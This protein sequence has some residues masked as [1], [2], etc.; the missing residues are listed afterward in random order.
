MSLITRGLRFIE[1][2][3]ASPA[4]QPPEGK[5][6]IHE[7]K[8][9]GFRCQ[10]LLERGRTRIFTRLSFSVA[11]ISAGG[12]AFMVTSI[13]MNLLCCNLGVKSGEARGPTNEGAKRLPLERHIDDLT[14][15]DGIKFWMSDG[16][17]P[18]LCRVSHGCEILPNAFTSRAL[19]RTS[20]K[21]IASL[22]SRSQ[23]MLT[24]PVRA[25]ITL[26]SFSSLPR[27]SPEWAAAHER[28]PRA[29]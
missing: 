3:L 14:A 27:R 12:C 11:R 29:V 5:Q 20:S 17:C 2:Q 19:T 18:V 8:H 23:A 15:R 10:V 6:W 16:E 1:P 4:D 24:T 13:P 26:A 25:L 7:I 9:D 21:P 22:L 28:H